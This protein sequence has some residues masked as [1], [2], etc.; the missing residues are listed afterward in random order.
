MSDHCKR[1]GADLESVADLH[2]FVCVTLRDH[3][4]RDPMGDHNRGRWTERVEAVVA[5]LD[6]RQANLCGSCAAGRAA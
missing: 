6:A 2:A 5:S 3:L 1:C 4:D